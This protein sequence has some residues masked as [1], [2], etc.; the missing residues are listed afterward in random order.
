MGPRIE[1]RGDDVW[2]VVLEHGARASMGPRIEIRGDVAE[3]LPDPQPVLASMGPR[4]EIR[5]DVA[6]IVD[7]LCVLVLLQWGRGSR[8]AETRGL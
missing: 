6:V 3:T 1:I 7:A 2:V 4:I 8:S 5:G